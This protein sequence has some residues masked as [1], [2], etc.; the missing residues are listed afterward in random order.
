MVSVKR[1]KTRKVPAKKIKRGGQALKSGIEAYCFDALTR[2]G[3]DFKYESEVI[4]LSPAF[5]FS[6]V[7]YKS[8]KGKPEMIN[9]TGKKV[10]PVTYKPDFVSHK[11]KFIIE[12]KGFVPSQHTFHIRWKMFLKHVVDNGMEDYMIFLPKNNKQV[13]ICINKIKDEIRTK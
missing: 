2:E 5:T 9:A 13:D 7:Y 6:G 11:H 12:T 1:N 8:T 10:L 3:I 4:E